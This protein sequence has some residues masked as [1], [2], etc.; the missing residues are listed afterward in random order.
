[1]LRRAPLT[2]VFNNKGLRKKLDL[3]IKDKIA[4]QTQ[5]EITLIEIS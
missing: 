5:L 2:S 4:D 1:M 3:L